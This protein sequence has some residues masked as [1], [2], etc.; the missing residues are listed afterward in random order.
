MGI[1][2]RRQHAHRGVNAPRFETHLGWQDHHETLCAF[3]A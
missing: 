1:V 2:S 3:N